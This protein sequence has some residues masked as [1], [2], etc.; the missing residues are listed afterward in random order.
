MN[1]K[2]DFFFRKAK[3][4]QTEL[5][6]LRIIA[7]DS[8]LTEELKWGVPCYTFQGNNVVLIHAFKDYCALLFFKGVLMKDKHGLLIQ[9]TKHVQAARQIR[10]TGV[11]EILNLQPRVRAYIKEAIE[12]EKSGVKVEFKKTTEFEMPEE[13]KIMLKEF[14]ALKVAF[15]A[16]TPGRQRAYLLFFAAP[17]QS[18]T[19]ESRIEKNIQR[20]L[21]G[22]GLDD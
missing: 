4:W 15:E 13:F 1:P 9:Q 17:K 3:K 5:E 11:K 21:D 16:L 22:I 18:K 6:H 7:L 2:V 19:R 14:P 8:G 10:F 12:L 20:I